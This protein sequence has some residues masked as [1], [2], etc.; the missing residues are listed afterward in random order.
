MDF[1]KA[2]TK[3]ICQGNSYF[4]ATLA[5]NPLIYSTKYITRLLAGT[6]GSAAPDWVTQETCLKSMLGFIHC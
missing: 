3:T 6:K 2:T 1:A 4:A 5:L